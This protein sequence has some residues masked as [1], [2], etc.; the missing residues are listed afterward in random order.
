MHRP[1]AVQDAAT[2]RSEYQPVTLRLLVGQAGGFSV[3]IHGLAN[4]QPGSLFE[5]RG[6]LVRW[7]TT[8]DPVRPAG[9]FSGSYVGYLIAVHMTEQALNTTWESLFQSRL[10]DPLGITDFGWGGPPSDANENP[11]GHTLTD[12]VWVET[13]AELPPYFSA[14]GR[15]YMSLGSWGRVLQE[16]L[17]ADV[18]QSAI[19]PQQVAQVLTSPITPAYGGGWEII[20]EPVTWTTGR[21]LRHNGLHHASFSHVQMAPDRGA[22][23]IAVTNG[24]RDFEPTRDMLRATSERLWKYLTDHQ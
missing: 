17:K 15:A 10:L 14:A 24:Y 12:G 19:V 5:Q 22:A 21:A 7:E 4:I 13:T 9:V 11:R 6:K 8:F 16:M 3:N 23:V 1:A 2:I 18:G 20:T